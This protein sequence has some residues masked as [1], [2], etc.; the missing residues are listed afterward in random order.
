[1]DGYG[2]DF[3][4]RRALISRLGPGQGSLTKYD[5][6]AKLKADTAPR[7][8]LRA[9]SCETICSLSHQPHIHTHLLYNITFRNMSI[10]STMKAVVVKEGKT[11]AVEEKPVPGNLGSKEVLLKVLTVAQSRL[12]SG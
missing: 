11:T 7:R 9:S 12:T 10:P 8:S 5:A 4:R 3:G 2:F 6:V 1:M